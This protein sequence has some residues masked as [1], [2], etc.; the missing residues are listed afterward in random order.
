LSPVKLPNVL[1]LCLQPGF[2]VLGAGRFVCCVHQGGTNGFCGRI[3]QPSCCAGR[4]GSLIYT[5]LPVVYV[6]M[7]SVYQTICVAA[8]VTV[9]SD[10]RNGQNVCDV[11]DV[12]LSIVPEC[13]NVRETRNSIHRTKIE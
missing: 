10:W 8:S 11:L 9:I 4:N 7:L 6:M 13:D 12:V 2:D 5:D 3:E 1:I